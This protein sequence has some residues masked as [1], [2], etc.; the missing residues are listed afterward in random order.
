MKGLLS[1]IGAKA[2]TSMAYHPR[3]DGQSE[4]SNQWLGQYL[5]PWTNIQQDNWEPYLPIAEFAC[6]S[7]HNETTRQSP[8]KIL[9]GYE[10][11]AKVSDAPTPLPIL[12]L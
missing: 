8:F 5:R 7:W 9:M 12:E 2:N 10:P 4:R 1:M 11:Q 3:T 6:N